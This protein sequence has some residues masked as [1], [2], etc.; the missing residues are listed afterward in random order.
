VKGVKRPKVESYEGKTPALGD[1]QAWA[2]LDAPGAETE[3]GKRDRAILSVLLYYGLRREL[4]PGLA[5][6]EAHGIAKRGEG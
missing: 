3:K 4:A 2:L 1:G 5:E 6:Q